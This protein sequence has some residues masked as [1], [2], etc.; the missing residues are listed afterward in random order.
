MVAIPKWA[1][2]VCANVLTGATLIAGM[3]AWPGAT[4]AAQSPGG[5]MDARSD[6]T[7][8]SPQP[9]RLLGAPGAPDVV[10]APAVPPRLDDLR[11][12]VR[13]RLGPWAAPKQ[14]VLAEALPRTPLGKVRRGEL[15]PLAGPPAG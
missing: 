10:P 5:R 1:P 15:A 4:L 9:S 14:L 13:E 3:A 8:S 6:T 11:A 12:A 2:G 7:R